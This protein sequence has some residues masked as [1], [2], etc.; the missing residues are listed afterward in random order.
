MSLVLIKKQDE[1]LA[2]TSARFLEDKLQKSKNFIL[3]CSGGSSLKIFDEFNPDNMDWKGGTITVL[4]ERYTDKVDSI[5]SCGLI[6]NGSIKKALSLGAKFFEV[7]DGDLSV[8]IEEKTKKFDDFLTGWI[9]KNPDGAIYAT[10]GMGSDGHIAGIF[11][12][13]SSEDFEITYKTGDFVVSHSKGVGEFAKRITITPR[14]IE[15]I[16]DIILY[17]G[18]A[19]KCEILTAGLKKDSVTSQLPVSLLVK[20]KNLV[21][22]A[23][24]CIIKI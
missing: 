21:H 23:T 2:K 14:F 9:E 10:V 17:V 7:N 5:N 8:S 18:G 1:S 6:E 12:D 19:D 4:D 11:P 15:K 13:N 20:G 22:L 16:D 3:L 24:D